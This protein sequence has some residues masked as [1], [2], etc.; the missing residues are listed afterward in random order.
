MTSTHL[1]FTRSGLSV[2]SLTD[3]PAGYYPADGQE[4]ECVVVPGI[5]RDAHEV[6][7]AYR[8]TFGV[9]CPI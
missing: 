9:A 7:A 6:R 4:A 5:C 3:R 1:A 8:A 2:V